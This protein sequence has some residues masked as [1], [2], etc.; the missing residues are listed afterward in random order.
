[1]PRACVLLHHH[2]H[3]GVCNVC[4]CGGSLNLQGSDVSDATPGWPCTHPKGRRGTDMPISMF[5][6]VRDRTP[7]T[8]CA[9][10]I[11][12]PGPCVR[13]RSNPQD[14][15]C[16]RDQTPR[17]VCACEIEPPKPKRPVSASP[18]HTV[19]SPACHFPGHNHVPAPDALDVALCAAICGRRERARYTAVCLSL[20]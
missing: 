19:H 7:R 6:C 16:V 14:R 5:G 9:C 1:M 11:E 3:R 4:A 2:P 13:A 15:V 18:D 8:V 17:A 12:P 10:E 20:V